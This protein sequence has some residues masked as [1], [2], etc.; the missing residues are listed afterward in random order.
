MQKRKMAQ[1]VVSVMQQKVKAQAESQ[2][3]SKSSA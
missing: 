3:D 1:Q 2:G